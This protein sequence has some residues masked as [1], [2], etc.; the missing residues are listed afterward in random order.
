[1]VCSSGK[2]DNP[3]PELRAMPLLLECPI[4]PLAWVLVH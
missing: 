1:M 4:Q 3:L 2:V